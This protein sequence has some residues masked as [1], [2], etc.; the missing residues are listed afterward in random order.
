MDVYVESI[1]Q[2][3]RFLSMDA[4]S[5]WYYLDES[6]KI[7]IW[8]A[9]RE[10]PG[11]GGAFVLVVIMKLTQLLLRMWSLSIDVVMKMR[12][13]FVKPNFHQRKRKLRNKEICYI[14]LCLCVGLIVLCFFETIHTRELLHS[15][16]LDIQFFFIEILY[17]YTFF[18]LCLWVNTWAIWEP[19]GRDKSKRKTLNLTNFVLFYIKFNRSILFLEQRDVTLTNKIW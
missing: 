4:P 13:I 19:M 6:I 7:N 17:K 1:L 3:G 2:D 14:K 16:Q 8:E 5:L 11:G 15:A 18:I 10:G 9:E 12:I